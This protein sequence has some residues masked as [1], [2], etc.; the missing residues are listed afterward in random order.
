DPGRSYTYV[1]G[2]VDAHP[3]FYALWA[4]GNAADFS[5][6][7]IYISS[8]QG[9]AFRLPPLMVEDAERPVAVGGAGNSSLLQRLLGG[10]PASPRGQ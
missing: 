10:V 1:R 7:D 6:S 8:A 4:D 9:S 2:A 3:D 5:T